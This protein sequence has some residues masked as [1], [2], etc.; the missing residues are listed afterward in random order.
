MQVALSC[1]AVTSSSP[2]SPGAPQF[3]E[4]LP[5]QERQVLDAASHPWDGGHDAQVASLD[6]SPGRQVLGAAQVM[7][8]HDLATRQDDKLGSQAYPSS[9][10]SKQCGS[11]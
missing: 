4:K 10:A 5:L 9:H 7:S 2:V 6:P 11:G 3:G 8:A 1:L